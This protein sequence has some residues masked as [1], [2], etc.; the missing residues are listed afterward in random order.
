MHTLSDFRV[1]SRPGG[2][3]EMK[4]L[5]KILWLVCKN[6]DLLINTNHSAGDAVKIIFDYTLYTATTF[7]TFLK[8]LRIK[9]NCKYLDYISLPVRTRDASLK[10]SKSYT[11]LNYS[12]QS[13]LHW[14][15]RVLPHIP[16]IL[17]SFRCSTLSIVALQS[18]KYWPSRSVKIKV[19]IWLPAWTTSVV[20]PSI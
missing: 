19:I 9:P 14:N 1:R 5:G 3:E 2:G 12:S 8:S 20:S 6:F 15:A 11:K 10:L 4:G 18:I 13:S 7:S 16:T 17:V